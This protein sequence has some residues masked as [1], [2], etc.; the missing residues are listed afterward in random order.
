MI[1]ERRIESGPE[2][3]WAERSRHRNEECG[4]EADVN[5]SDKRCELSRTGTLLNVA[6]RHDGYDSVE[7]DLL[8]A[9]FHVCDTCQPPGGELLFELD[10]GASTPP[11]NSSTGN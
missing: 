2:D 9:L 4:R 10:D 3:I 8:D 1:G 6:W 7:A 5:L 11:M